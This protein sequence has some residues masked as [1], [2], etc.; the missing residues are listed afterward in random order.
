MKTITRKS[1]WNYDNDE[2]YRTVETIETWEWSEELNRYELVNL[3]DEDGDYIPHNESDYIRD[4]AVVFDEEG[5]PTDSI[6]LKKKKK[7]NLLKAV[8][9]R[10]ADL[11]KK[12]EKHGCSVETLESDMTDKNLMKL[13]EKQLMFI[14]DYDLKKYDP[15]TFDHRLD[16]CLNGRRARISPGPRK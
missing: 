8:K 12:A 15:P 6:E 4:G 7:A 13:S 14:L 5:R 1:T 11:L 16:C 3:V 10:Y 2:G 9:E